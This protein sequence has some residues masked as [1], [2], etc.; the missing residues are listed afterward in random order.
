MDHKGAYN[1]YLHLET[2]LSCQN[3]GEGNKRTILHDE[4]LFIVVHQ[5]QEL[6]FKVILHELK[7]I[8]DLLT[9]QNT[10][11]E[12]LVT[13]VKYLDRVKSIMRLSLDQLCVLDLLSPSDFTRIRSELGTAS[14]GQ[15]QQFRQVERIL[16]YRTEV[17]DNQRGPNRDSTPST[18][19][20][21][22][23]DLFDGVQ[24]WLEGLPLEGS[25]A[26]KLWREL[27]KRL[28]RAASEKLMCHDR[29][30]AP[31]AWVCSRKA[32]PGRHLSRRAFR[33]ALFLRLFNGSPATFLAESLLDSVIEIDALFV[34]W[35]A[36]HIQIA[37][38]MIG[39]KRGTGGSSGL[40]GL[41]SR[42]GL[43]GSFADLSSVSTFLALWDNKK[44]TMPSSVAEEIERY[45]AGA[46]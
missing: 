33:S 40:D 4:T 30:L 44:P 43:E 23:Y 38:R 45:L 42:I 15:S 8:V 20:P 29:T 28:S 7:A 34:R 16:G 3:G 26:R 27:L 37:H 5:V 1:Q 25:A 32:Q 18:K 2:I 39:S 46:C 11:N 22:G 10:A 6:W 21:S 17:S 13:V 41:K 24:C 36:R 19:Q 35:R 14:G 31:G 12:R 9:F